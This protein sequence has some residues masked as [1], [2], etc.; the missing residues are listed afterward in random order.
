MYGGW[1]D[2]IVFKKTI[3]KMDPPKLMILDIDFVLKLSN[4]RSSK[5]FICLKWILKFP[6]HNCNF[7]STQGVWNIREIEPTR[8]ALPYDY[9]CFAD[10]TPFVKEIFR[11]GYYIRG[12]CKS[13]KYFLYKWSTRLQS[14]YNH[15][16]G[17]PRQFYL[18][19]IPYSLVQLPYIAGH[20]LLEAIQELE[21]I[22]TF[23]NC[24]WSKPQ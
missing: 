17:W 2:L 15:M 21:T 10:G 6:L 24:I 9:T 22:I 18:P 3:L 12:N 4:Y 19:S 5:R 1:T 23:Q 20:S 13:D 7:S 16:I 14:M 8:P 11:I